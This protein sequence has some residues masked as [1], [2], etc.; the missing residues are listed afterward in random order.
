MSDE[1]T[2]PVMLHANWSSAIPNEKLQHAKIERL[3]RLMHNKAKPITEVTDYEALLWVSTEAMEHPIGHDWFNIYAH[4]FSKFFPEQAAAIFSEYE[5]KRPLDLSEQMELTELKRK[6]YTMSI[7]RL[8][9]A[10]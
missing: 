2:R 7:R 5:L 6:L 10:S 8:K 4:L 3:K 9:D 1:M